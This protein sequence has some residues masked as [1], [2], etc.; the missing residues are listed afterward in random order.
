MTKPQAPCL[1]CE[2]SGTLHDRCELYSKYK[3][4]IDKWNKLCYEARSEEYFYKGLKYK[5]LRNYKKRK[6]IKDKLDRNRNF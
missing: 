4:D 5:R 2:N 3:A 6:G 1:G